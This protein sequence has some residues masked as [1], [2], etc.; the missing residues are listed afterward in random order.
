MIRE[1]LNLRKTQIYNLRKTMKLLNVKATFDVKKNF[2]KSPL[3]Q[4]MDQRDGN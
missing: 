3:D 2:R 1:S 4:M